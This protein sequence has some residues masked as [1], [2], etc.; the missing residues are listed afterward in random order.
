M[1]KRK[2]YPGDHGM[3]QMNHKKK[4]CCSHV[5]KEKKKNF[6]RSD[7]QTCICFPHAAADSEEKKKQKVK[8]PAFPPLS[9]RPEQGFARPGEIRP[10]P[11]FHQV[12]INPKLATTLSNLR[13]PTAQ[14]H[15][16]QPGRRRGM[17]CRTRGGHDTRTGQSGIDKSAAGPTGLWDRG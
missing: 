10:C 1:T 12:I 6:V 5:K 2:L 8:R 16:N 3:N 14:P 4:G 15:P 9:R 17:P 11:L 7:K 13:F